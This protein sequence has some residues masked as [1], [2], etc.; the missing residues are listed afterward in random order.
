MTTLEQ[1]ENLRSA[2]ELIARAAGV[3]RCA[4]SVHDFE[5]GFRFA[6]DGD[7]LFH[8]AST[9]KVAILL[10]LFKGVDDGRFRLG[11]SLHVRN[12]F[13]SAVGGAP[14]RLEAETDGYPSLYKAIG[15]TAKIGD[16]AENMIIWSSNLATNLLL[17]FIG[18]SYA[19]EVLTAVGVAGLH[20]RR[21]VADESAFEAGLNNE[22][23]A[24]GLVQ[25]FAALRGEF[26]S[27]PSRE[28]VIQIL[29]NQKFTSMI[30][31]GLPAHATVAHKT[32]EI[33]T[34][35]H[36]AGI[37]YL[38]EREPYI[39]AILTEVDSEKNERR[40][41]VRTLSEAVYEAVTGRKGLK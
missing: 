37:V 1:P 14:F 2:I 22:T 40:E 28:Q 31:A 3:R 23:S 13:H 34:A 33:S 4:V 24:D 35:C 16:L 10:A 26:L 27:K 20:L 19:A 25:L 12:R 29:L 6:L 8:A 11:D 15:R 7:R 5:T 38:P 21:G 9:I 17:D 32:G 39:V 18:S 41:T 30:P 36:D